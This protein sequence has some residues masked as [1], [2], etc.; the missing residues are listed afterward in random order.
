MSLSDKMRLLQERMTPGPWK[1]N[2]AGKN[3][4]ISDTDCM[5]ICRTP[6]A[7][8]QKTAPANA[9][10]IALSDLLPRLVVALE[11]ARLTIKALH[12]PTAWDIYDQHSPEM[13]RINA[14][15]AEIDKRVGE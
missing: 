14:L 13:K 9:T 6:G 4:V 5:V 15:L 8:Y 1:I 7:L 12:G 3:E 11:E 2:P 10:V